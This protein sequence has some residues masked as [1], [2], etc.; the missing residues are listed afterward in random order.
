[1]S[2]LRRDI[3]FM[4]Q[5]VLPPPGTNVLWM[6]TSVP[7]KPVLKYFNNGNWV[8]CHT[9]ESKEISLL[10]NSV[11]ELSTVTTKQ[12]Q[13]INELSTYTAKEVT[14][15]EI[16]EKVNTL[17]IETIA[18]ESS[19][20]SA[21]SEAIAAKQVASAIT[22]Y[23]LQGSDP[24]A[25]N[26]AIL[27]AIPDISGL[28]TETN[29]T[30]NKNAILAEI[31]PLLQAA[32]AYNTGKTE[33]AANI[34][35]KGVEA[36]ASETLPVLAEKVATIV[37][38][39]ALDGESVTGQ[40]IFPQPYVWNLIEEAYAHQNGEYAGLILAE[41][42]KGYDSIPL[43]GA[44]AY[45]T[46]DGDFYDAATTHV[47]HDDNLGRVNRYV[48]YYFRNEYSPF[49][50]GDASTCPRRMTVLGK[51]GAISSSIAGRITNI[52]N[53]G[54]ILDI[55]FSDS[56]PWNVESC[57]KLT[58]HS[59]GS[60]FYIS[61]S[62]NNKL[63]NVFVQMDKMTGGSV[64]TTS[65]FGDF[66]S[67]INLTISVKKITGGTVVNFGVNANGSYS[68]LSEITFDGLEEL[69]GT[70]INQ[71]SSVNARITKLKRVDVSSLRLMKESAYI[72]NNNN[73]NALS[74][75]DVIDLSS[76]EGYYSEQTVPVALIYDCGIKSLNLP[77]FKSWKVIKAWTGD[78]T[79]II[80]NCN[81]LKSIY[82]DNIEETIG[83]N[84]YRR[85]ASNCGILEYVYFGYDE[86][87][88]TKPINLSVSNCPMLTD[89]ELK[90]GYNKPIVLST[91]NN[92]TEPNMYAHILQRLKQ[93]EPDCG[94]GVTITL[95][96]TNLAKLTSEESVQLLDDLTNIYGYT[97]A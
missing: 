1:M 41:F 4:V 79:S 3:K 62:T 80:S 38:A 25:T 56:Q 87:D 42:Y 16:L 51:I 12:Q 88:K 74:N 31:G 24:T 61:N 86:N 6:D 5:D 34:T 33:L 50:I 67:L 9:D 27:Q 23:A 40:A 89:V 47:W 37:Q 57:I 59:G 63:T 46:C 10:V 49:I 14:S 78:G 15:Q 17:D 2:L 26:T 94:D 66:S 44:D 92:M 82:L 32:E 85:L 55:R 20:Q 36:S 45:Y 18:K 93:D 52:Y 60:I 19:V 22:G 90:D 13:T 91:F 35:S 53:C 8:P 65:N 76:L 39:P 72:I 97:F 75:I 29:A 84:S 96:S 48:I 28:A 11:K 21:I 43:G 71:S 81:K 68:S 73:D 7:D 77:R 64:I 58:E 69:Q 83:H 30:A 54:E 70:L 95:G